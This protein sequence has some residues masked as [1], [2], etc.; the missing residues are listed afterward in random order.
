MSSILIVEDDV[1]ASEHLEFVL[2]EAGY[3]A[4]PAAVRKKQSPF[5]NIATTFTSS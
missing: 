1:L 3:E 5:S 2:E 4:I